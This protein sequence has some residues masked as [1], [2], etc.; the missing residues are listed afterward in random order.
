MEK[1]CIYYV[2]G[3]TYKVKQINAETPEE[4]IKRAR[5][6]NIID[7]QTLQAEGGADEIC[8]S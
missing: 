3:N 1:W 2:V 5:V 4:A 7:I 6:K 8:I